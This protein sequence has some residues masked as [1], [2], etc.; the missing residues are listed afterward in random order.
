MNKPAFFS[1]DSPYYPIL[2]LSNVIITTLLVVMSA[3][4]TVIANNSIQGDLA[5]SNTQSTWTTTLYLLGINT[6]V[7]V[8]TWLANR[9][10]YKRMYTYG[11]LLFTFGSAV[12]GF[13][14]NFVVLAI[15]RVLEGVG[16]GLVFPI[17][18]ALIV[19]CLSKKKIVLALNLYIGGAFGGG[20]GLGIPIAGYLTQFATWRA[21][22]WLI[23]PLGGLAALSCWLSR[24]KVS[25][26]KKEPFD[27]WGFLTFATFI[28]SLLIALTLAP[29]KATTM[30]WRSWY[31]LALLA[32]AVI[33]L[34]LTIF[35]ERRHPYPNLPIVLFK[36]PIFTTCA[37][38]MFLLG[39]SLFAS[40]AVSMDYMINA[41]GYEKF[42]TGKIAM[43]YGITMAVCSI[44]ASWLMK[45][46]PAPF[47]T[48][49]GL[50]CLVYSYFLNN[51]LSWL[52]G[53]NQVMWILF[54]RGVG[55][56]LSLGPTTLLALHVVP[57]EL[58]NAAATLLTFFR[59]IG[60][61]YGGT[62]IAIFSIR[63]MIFHA[64]RFGEQTNDQLPAYKKTF[65]NLYDK[66][67]DAARA[68]A[69]IVK[70]I[71]IQAYVQGLNDAMI[72]FGYVTATVAVF[73]MLS[74]AFRF[75]KKGSAPSNK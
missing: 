18:L 34:I 43:I 7:P 12:V 59:Q 46:I 3:V 8:A 50:S 39:M 15:A 72:I 9:L 5:L 64:A 53:V 48:F 14:N 28:A 29:I 20:L 25:E 54:I 44:L 66:F 75:L 65:Y 16:G 32:L 11:V 52:T 19:Q 4:A 31:I 45:Y 2:I 13:S 71:E 22:F 67:P 30:G 17:G 35:I 21:I 41:L 38:A 51:E 63:Q 73:L 33:C 70:N 26:I 60:N 58:R 24:Q 27:H 36:D 40:V 10:G 61:T 42:T 47:L 23:I 6:T 49:A 69:T 57:T 55:I 68:K 37:A 62:L 74:V 56:G 1:S